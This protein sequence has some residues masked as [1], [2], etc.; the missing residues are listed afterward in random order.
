MATHSGCVLMCSACLD[1]LHH[2]IASSLSVAFS[3]SGSDSG[4][5]VLLHCSSL[6]SSSPLI[7]LCLAG[8]SRRASCSVPLVFQFHVW[9]RNVVPSFRSSG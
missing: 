4:P 3:C 8:E 9:V 7:L 6:G 2:C 5:L 1:F